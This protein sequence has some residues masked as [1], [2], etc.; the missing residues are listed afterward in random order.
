[1]MILKIKKIIRKFKKTPA[2]ETWLKSSREQMISF[3][4]LNPVRKAYISR[5]IVPEGIFNKLILKPMPIAIIA[6][7]IS[8]A[9]G[10]GVVT[11][12]QTSLPTDALY[13]VKI[14]TEQIQEAI[15]FNNAKK[16]DLSV[17]LAEKR[18]DEIN[19]LQTK[20]EVSS[21]VIK[22]TIANYEKH[23][24]R[25][26][27][28]LASVNGDT[29]TQ[30]VIA[31]ALKYENSLEQQQEK[32]EVLASQSSVESQPSWAKAQKSAIAKSNLA[33]EKI[34]VKIQETETS[35]NS[36]SSDSVAKNSKAEIISST[37]M[38]KIPDYIP[39]IENKTKNRLNAAEKKLEEIYKKINNFAK[40]DE[41][42]CAL[43]NKEAYLEKLDRILEAMRAS[44]A[45]AKKLFE[46]KDY[47]AALNQ[48]NFIMSSAVDADNLVGQW[49]GSCEEVIKPQRTVQIISL[50]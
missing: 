17:K 39:G 26:Q 9:A 48:A 23:L 15:T 30:K 27:S 7:V 49:R 40:Q 42:K 35:Q 10:G 21:T 20:T 44:L 8:L 14:A 1:M 6:L 28:Q 47:L 2:D 24:A 29:A 50:N 36:V 31:A 3:I 43:I 18:L 19:L 37:A 46:Q 22:K 5:Q 4:K 33:L 16:V 12:S 11:A 25:A 32:L 45:E 13:P 38:E 41:N 34:K